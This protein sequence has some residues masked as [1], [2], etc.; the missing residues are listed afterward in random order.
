MER[1]KLS[2]LL[3][4]LWLITRG[5]L[6]QGITKMV[7]VVEELIQ[8]RQENRVFKAIDELAARNDSLAAS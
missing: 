1:A 6:L 4:H 8:L 3:S 7:K 5:I 2:I